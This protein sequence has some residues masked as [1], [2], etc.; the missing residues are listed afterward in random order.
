MKSFES[1]YIK[2]E[3][4]LRKDRIQK[5]GMLLLNAN[6]VKLL[7]LFNELHDDELSLIPNL[8]MGELSLCAAKWHGYSA[9]RQVVVDSDDGVVIYEDFLEADIEQKYQSIIL[10]PTFG[11]RTK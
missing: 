5:N 7:K 11:V 10:F 4:V 3:N 9:E 8:S 6:T 1:E 2:F